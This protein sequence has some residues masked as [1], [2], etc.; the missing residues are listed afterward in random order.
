MT[1]EERAPSPAAKIRGLAAMLRIL[2]VERH[3]VPAE[4]CVRE[5]CSICGSLECPW[6]DP[7]HFQEDGCPSCAGDPP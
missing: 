2:H 4:K 3:G 5:T 1:A 6:G 7:R